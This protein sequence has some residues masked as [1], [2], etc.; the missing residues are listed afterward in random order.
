MTY[1]RALLLALVALALPAGS[2]A[3]KPQ[4]RNWVATFTVT[5]QGGVVQGNPNARVR[6]VEYGSRTCPTCLRFAQ[7]GMEPLRAKYIARGK[8]SYEFRDFWVHPQDPGISLLGNCVPVSRYYPLLDAMFAE[9]EKLN[10]AMNPALFEEIG[11]LPQLQQPRAYARRLGYV[12]LL[13]RRGM[14]EARALQCLGDQ[15]LL[16]RIEDRMRVGIDA[17]VQGTP[18]FF[19]NGRKLDNVYLWSQ[20]EPQLQAAGG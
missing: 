16:K 15:A 14:P 17:G 6:L 8:V 13:K 19:I 4:A 10:A 20:I 11:K 12:D 3:A 2:V 18:S 9:Q 7:E 1:L 5:P